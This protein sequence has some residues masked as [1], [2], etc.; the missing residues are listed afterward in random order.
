MDPIEFPGHNVIFAKDQPQYRPLPAYR[1]P[2]DPA[3]RVIF[4]WKLTPE[5]LEE[6]KR[7]GCLWQEV[8]TFDQPLQPQRLRTS[9]PEEVPEA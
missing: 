2:E 4:C 7:T 3:G 8:M 9:K 6:I 5:E 1:V